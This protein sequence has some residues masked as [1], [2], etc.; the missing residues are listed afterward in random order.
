[1]FPLFF[2]YVYIC[3]FPYLDVLLGGDVVRGSFHLVYSHMSA[4][5]RVEVKP[6]GR[7][8]A[9]S[10]SR[11][12]YVS[13]R[14]PLLQVD[15]EAFVPASARNLARLPSVGDS[16]VHK[17]TTDK[18]TCKLSL[19]MPHRCTWS[20]QRIRRLR[21]LLSLGAQSRLNSPSWSSG[22]TSTCPANGPPII[23]STTDRSH[24]THFG[25]AWL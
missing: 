21:H 20:S 8:A 19:L 15:T 22:T 18:P 5:E 1:M 10:C 7:T 9:H 25:I 16:S 13:R 4:H 12:L 24:L 23:I 3:V 11:F 14:V 2:S 6:H 17:A